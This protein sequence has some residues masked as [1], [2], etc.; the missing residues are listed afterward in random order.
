MPRCLRM[1]VERK[2]FRSGGWLTYG[3]VKHNIPKKIFFSIVKNLFFQSQNSFRV[4][5][6]KI[7]FGISDF[8]P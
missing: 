1:L 5:V 6:K 8:Y 4:K 7:N 3:V 2:V